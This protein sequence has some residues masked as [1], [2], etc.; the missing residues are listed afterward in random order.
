MSAALRLQVRN[1]MST[2]QNDIE[3]RVETPKQLAERVGISEGKVRHLIRGDLLEHVWIG[4]RVYIPA[5]AWP[6]FIANQRG[7]SCR[8]DD[9]EA[10]PFREPTQSW[11]LV[12]GFLSMSLETLHRVYA[13]HH[14]DFQRRAVENIGRRPQNVR[15]IV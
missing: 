10:V 15:I 1:R 2:K 8:A 14:P 9:I 4:C 13:H 7:G 3:D 11:P 12:S 6:R 5:G